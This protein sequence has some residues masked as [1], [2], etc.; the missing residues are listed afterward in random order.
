MGE[1][2]LAGPDGVVTPVSAPKPV[3]PRRVS[4]KGQ[5]QIDE[6]ERAAAAIAKAAGKPSLFPTVNVS[7]HEPDEDLI[8]RALTGR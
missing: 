7:T 6:M 5:A 8:Q 3:E 1:W 2:G 4:A